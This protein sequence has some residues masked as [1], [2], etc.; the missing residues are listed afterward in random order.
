MGK[1]EH[2]SFAVPALNAFQQRLEALKLMYYQQSQV[3]DV[4]EWARVKL[5]AFK[6]LKT[7]CREAED[8][9]LARA[10]SKEVL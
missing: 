3:W 1:T 10:V 9:A 6:D 2:V 4:D 7:F 8:E 5:E